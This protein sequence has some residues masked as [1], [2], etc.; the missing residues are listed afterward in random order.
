MANLLLEGGGDHPGFWRTARAAAT[1]PPTVLNRLVFGERFTPV[2][3]SHDPAT[4]L[5][6]RAGAEVTTNVSQYGSSRHGRIFREDRSTAV[7]F[8]S[9]CVGESCCRIMNLCKWELI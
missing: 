9:P 6:L 5:R 2:F 1:S 8:R 7:S 4:L 3:P